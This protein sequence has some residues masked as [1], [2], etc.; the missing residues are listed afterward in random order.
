MTRWGCGKLILH[1]E[2]HI[3]L[4]VSIHTSTSHPPAYIFSPENPIPRYPKSLYIILHFRPA[5][6]PRFR[7]TSGCGVT[8]RPPAE[9][10]S[11]HNPPPDQYL[12]RPSTTPR[13]LTQPRSSD[14]PAHSSINPSQ[15]SPP[16]SQAN[17]SKS[18]LANPKT[19]QSWQKMREL[20]PPA[21]SPAAHGLHPTAPTSPPNA[22]H[23]AAQ[24][25]PSSTSPNPPHNTALAGLK[26]HPIHL[27]KNMQTTQISPPEYGISVGIIGMGD[28]GRMYARRLASTGWK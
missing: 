26:S 8:R 9:C 22:S 25:P 16:I 17:I 5:V 3:N 10:P 4:L 23:P 27:P 21:A 18:P 12:T 6:E 2:N 7:L 11:V 19:P 13:N 1:V 20:T 14:S 28:M 24:T 15:C